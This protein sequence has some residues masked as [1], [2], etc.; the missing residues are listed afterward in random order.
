VHND[1][2]G[3]QSAATEQSSNHRNRSAS[4]ERIRVIRAPLHI[5]QR[6]EL[7]L[8]RKSSLAWLMHYTVFIVSMCFLIPHA[9][10]ESSYQPGKQLMVDLVS[11]F[12][13]HL[14]D[15][16]SVQCKADVHFDARGLTA[17]IK[18]QNIGWYFTDWTA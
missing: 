9:L 7:R 15:S 13:H 5:P 11:V 4:L 14:F 1:Q 3:N 8:R 2:D 10:P 18:V 16:R 12:E 17:T 6:P